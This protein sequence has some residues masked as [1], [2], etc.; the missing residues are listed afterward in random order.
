MLELLWEG[1]HSNLIIIR[2]PSNEASLAINT[3][4]D[5]WLIFKPQLSRQVNSISSCIYI[6]PKSKSNKMLTIDIRTVLNKG[7]ADANE[8]II[9]DSINLYFE[10]GFAFLGETVLTIDDDK[11]I[12]FLDDVIPLEL[13]LMDVL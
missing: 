2:K 5:D 12:I 9:R 4:P 10:V 11:D 13:V 1:D 3:H 8:H 7:I 6:A